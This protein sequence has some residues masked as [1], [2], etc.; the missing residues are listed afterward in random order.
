MEF[1]PTTK[2]RQNYLI[3]FQYFL[4][5]N[6]LYKRSISKQRYSQFFAGSVTKNVTKLSF[7]SKRI[8]AAQHAHNFVVNFCL[9]TTSI[10]MLSCCNV[11]HHFDLRRPDSYQTLMQMRSQTV[12][13]HRHWYQSVGV[14]HP[15]C[16]KPHGSLRSFSLWLERSSCRFAVTLLVFSRADHSTS[17]VLTAFYVV[18]TS[19]FCWRRTSKASRLIKPPADWSTT[20]T[21]H[22][23]V[24]NDA[25]SI[26]ISSQN[27]WLRR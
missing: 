22:S 11:D 15:C 12:A 6:K 7:A 23:A 27:I 5:Y 2:Y 9:Q 13:V 8:Q 18:F 19:T 24:N 10:V 4:Y 1:G 3:S 17:Q 25:H 26:R 20:V 21:S 16:R 14:D